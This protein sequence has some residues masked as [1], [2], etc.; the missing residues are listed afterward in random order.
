MTLA[1]FTY[2]TI[3]WLFN[4]FS[5]WINNITAKYKTLFLSEYMGKKSGTAWPESSNVQQHFCIIPKRYNWKWSVMLPV[6]TDIQLKSEAWCCL[7]E[8]TYK[9]TLIYE[10]YYLMGCATMWNTGECKYLPDYTV[11]YKEIVH[12]IISFY[13]TL[14]KKREKEEV[15]GRWGRRIK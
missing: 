10:Y 11:S 13:N 2:F 4:I 12:T 7:L 3:M 9:T 6:R 5:N 15:M 1:V 8:Q 14:L